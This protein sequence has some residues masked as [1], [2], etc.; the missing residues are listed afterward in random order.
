MERRGMLKVGAVY[1]ALVFAVG[2]ILGPIRELWI[3]PRLGRSAG[4]VIEAP[5]M[6]MAMMASARWVIR[7]FCVDNSFSTRTSIGLIATP[8][9]IVAEILGT[10]WTR[11]ASLS[12]YLATFDTVSGGVFVLLLVLF[13]AMPMLVE[14]GEHLSGRQGG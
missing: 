9:L 11:G 2:W 10:W 6:L 12:G 7:R 4:F 14:R 5:I 1:F 8:L 3:I 13:A